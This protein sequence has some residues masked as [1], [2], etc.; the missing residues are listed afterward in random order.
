V[1]AKYAF[2]EATE[3]ERPGQVADAVTGPVA[4][5]G[6]AELAPNSFSSPACCPADRA[7]AS[8]RAFAA[9]RRGWC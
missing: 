9:C 7:A 8:S 1:T 3:A 2:I 6:A 5:G 4:D